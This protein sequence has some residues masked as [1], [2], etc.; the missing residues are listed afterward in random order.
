MKSRSIVVGVAAVLMGVT[1]LAGATAANASTSR[2]GSVHPAWLGPIVHR[3]GYGPTLD[4]AE[5]DAEAQLFDACD[6]TYS[7]LIS[8]GQLSDGTWY[9]NMKGMCPAGPA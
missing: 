5:A 8:D 1:S 6:I 9:A 7:V 4:A 3:T 2:S